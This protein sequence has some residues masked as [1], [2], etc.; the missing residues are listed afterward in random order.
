MA[1]RKKQVVKDGRED[2]T[3]PPLTQSQRE[4][5]EVCEGLK[6]LLLT[7]NA[8]YG[9][10]ALKPMRV[11]SKADTVEQLKVRLDD[12]L[13]R[14]MRGHALPDESLKQ[15]VEDLMGYLV[16]LVIATRRREAIPGKRL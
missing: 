11:F 1:A 12:K 15:T 3:M 6:Q 7:K 16:L 9:D 14:L 8:A 4:I 10:S 13:S 2:A 5:V